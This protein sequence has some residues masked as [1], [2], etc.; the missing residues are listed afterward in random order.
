MTAYLTS[1]SVY[2][3]KAMFCNFTFTQQKKQGDVENE[4]TQGDVENEPHRAMLQTSP[5]KKLCLH[6]N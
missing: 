3:K 5:Q 2:R 1:Y 4:P 6:R